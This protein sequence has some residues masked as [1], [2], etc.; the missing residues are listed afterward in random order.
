[1]TPSMHPKQ[2]KIMQS[3][4]VIENILELM[5]DFATNS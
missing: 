4:H 2:R 5:V 1:M 3:I